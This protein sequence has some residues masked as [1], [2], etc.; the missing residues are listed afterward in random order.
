MK[1]VKEM[2]EKE[3]APVCAVLWAGVRGRNIVAL[4]PNNTL[5]MT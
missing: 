3:M 4:I 1:F 2:I 5:M